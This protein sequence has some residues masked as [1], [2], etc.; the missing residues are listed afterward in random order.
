[1]TVMSHSVLHQG[2]DIPGVYNVMFKVHFIMISHIAFQID[3]HLGVF[4]SRLFEPVCVAQSFITF[5]Y[6]VHRT[7]GSPPPKLLIMCS[8]DN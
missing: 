7:R 6:D 4:Q 1:M 8:D 3:E 5:S 2:T